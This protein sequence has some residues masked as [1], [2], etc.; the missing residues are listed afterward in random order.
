VKPLMYSQKE[1]CD[2][3]PGVYYYTVC[4]QYNVPEEEKESGWAYWHYTPN[5]Q[6]SVNP[7]I[8]N[9]RK[10]PP[11]MQR[12]ARNEIAEAE[13]RRKFSVKQMYNRRQANVIAKAE[14]NQEEKKDN[15]SGGR[16][17]RKHQTHKTHKKHRL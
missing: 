17:M 16:R 7:A 8:V 9:V 10:L 5:I 15:Q 13:T 6:K 14:A 12:I 1:L 2:L 3:L 4:R 11:H